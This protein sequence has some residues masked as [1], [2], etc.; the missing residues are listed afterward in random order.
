MKINGR[1][2]NI[3]KENMVIGASAKSCPE[4]GLLKNMIGYSA[5]E[6]VASPYKHYISPERWEEIQAE[7]KLKK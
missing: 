5:G 2:V 4:K 1:K 3:I 7:R 6:L